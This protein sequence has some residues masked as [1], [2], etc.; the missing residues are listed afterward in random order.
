MI[1][2]A[3]SNVQ[4]VQELLLISLA[5]FVDEQYV[6][7]FFASDDSHIRKRLQKFIN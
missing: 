5:E 4:F 3:D 6:G 1:L 7:A 2:A